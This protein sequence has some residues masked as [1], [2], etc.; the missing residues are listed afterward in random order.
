MSG[1]KVLSR[2]GVLPVSTR[3]NSAGLL[4]DAV[5]CAHAASRSTCCCVVC[6][7]WLWVCI[8]AEGGAVHGYC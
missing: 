7:V 1:N 6:G 8:Q 4:K 3:V 2:A 5:W